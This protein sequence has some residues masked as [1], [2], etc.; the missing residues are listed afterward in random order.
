MMLILTLH[1]DFQDASEGHAEVSVVV[2]AKDSL[3]RLL[4]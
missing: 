4:E 2:F 3:E 1:L